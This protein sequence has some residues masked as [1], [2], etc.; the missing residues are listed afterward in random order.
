ERR[1]PTTAPLPPISAAACAH[2]WPAAPA[3][4]R[5]TAAAV[6]R[7]ARA[8]CAVLR[9]GS[10]APVRRLLR[11]RG[12]DRGVRPRARL[13]RRGR[14]RAT[15]A[16]GVLSRRPMTRA[17]AAIVLSLLL[18]VPMPAAAR[19]GGGGGGGG[20]QLSFPSHGGS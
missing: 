10:R 3:R 4:G 9:R 16:A 13:R 12:A 6:A 17:L 2:L 7:D 15:A 8:L 19:Q 1:R 5:A 18:A 11:H 20:R 14:C